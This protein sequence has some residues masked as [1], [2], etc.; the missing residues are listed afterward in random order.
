MFIWLSLHL[1]TYT[2]NINPLKSNKLSNSVKAIRRTKKVGSLLLFNEIFGRE[3]NISTMGKI[4]ILW[5]FNYVK[6]EI[7]TPLIAGN[8]NN[9]F[10]MGEG[11]CISALMEIMQIS[12]KSQFNNMLKPGHESRTEN[13]ITFKMLATYY[14]YS[15]QIQ[16]QTRYFS[17]IVKLH[18]RFHS[19]KKDSFQNGNA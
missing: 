19:R 4:F 1:A 13:L 8:L 6:I 9:L 17:L 15:L 5:V 16:I 11:S 14:K 7:K 12:Q 18:E 3:K 2:R 10:S